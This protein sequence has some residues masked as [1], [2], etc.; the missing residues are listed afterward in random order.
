MRTIHEAYQFLYKR[1]VVDVKKRLSKEPVDE[2][3]SKHTRF[4]RKKIEEKEKKER[5]KDDQNQK[6]VQTKP[7]RVSTFRSKEE[8]EQ[9]RSI[10]VA[11][12]IMANEGQESKN[13]RY[14]LCR[15]S[16]TFLIFALKLQIFKTRFCRFLFTHRTHIYIFLI[17]RGS[18][19]PVELPKA[20]RYRLAILPTHIART[21]SA[22]LYY[23]LA[24][25]TIIRLQ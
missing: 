22:K 6:E 25:F 21:L 13:L 14:I 3:E 2:F 1:Y 7:K 11:N 23:G 8:L 24:E 4:E 19:K 10:S 9:L 18:L 5:K 16:I 20:T 15:V 17:R 12:K